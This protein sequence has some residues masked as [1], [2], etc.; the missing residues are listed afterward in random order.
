MRA[1]SWF[2]ACIGTALAGDAAARRYRRP[3]VALNIFLQ[4]SLRSPSGEGGKLRY[5]APHRLVAHPPMSKLSRETSSDNHSLSYWRRSLA[6]PSLIA[7][8]FVYFDL[9]KAGALMSTSSISIWLQLRTDEASRPAQ[10]NTST[11]TRMDAD[12]V[13]AGSAS[14]TQFRNPA[15]YVG[16]DRR[17]SLPR[18][19]R[20][21]RMRG[22]PRSVAGPMGSAGVLHARAA[23]ERSADIWVRDRWRSRPREALSRRQLVHA[24]LHLDVG[25]PAIRK[26]TW[27]GV[28]GVGCAFTWGELGL[29]YG[30]LFFPSKMMS[31]FESRS[32]T[33][34]G[35]H[36]VANFPFVD[37]CAEPAGRHGPRRCGPLRREEGAAT[38]I[39]FGFM[40]LCTRRLHACGRCGDGAG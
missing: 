8:V 40:R 37:D 21:A 36:S 24:V 15:S 1:V 33:S 18:R 31:K 10:L 29:T 27:Q 7:T 32:W 22:S 4:P 38:T 13:D 26:L 28:I 39:R 3:A 23:L 9:R 25:V 34:A 5:R 30:C 35:S 16:F 14:T 2:H 6:R 11:Q 20:P 19:C 12:D 17:V